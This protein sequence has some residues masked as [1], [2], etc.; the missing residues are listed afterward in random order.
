MMRGFAGCLSLGMVLALAAVPIACQDADSNEASSPARPEENVQSD[1][2]SDAS[3]PEGAFAFSA[4]SIE[5][6]PVE[7]SR[8]QGKVL[9][10][11]NVASR[12]GNTPQYADLETLYEEKKDRG[13]VVLGFP[14]ND[15]GSQ[16]PGTNAQIRRFCT[17]K[18]GVSFPMFAKI[19]VKGQEQHP[20]YAWLTDEQRHPETGGSIRWNFDKFLI[21]RD[22]KVIAR[23]SPRT[24]PSSDE[25]VA[26]VDAA[27]GSQG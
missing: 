14:A 10:I 26:A 6:E 16:E 18:Y 5:G 13:L 8:Y 15:F 7:L 2:P 12:C 1:P 27:I 17:S 4:R 24:N 11:V 3:E 9:L 21:G 20:L 22:G 19:S 25:V 23:F